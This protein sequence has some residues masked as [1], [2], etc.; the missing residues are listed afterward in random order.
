MS[1]PISSRCAA[2]KYLRRRCPQDCIFSPYFPS[3]DPQRFAYVHRI[4]GASNVGKLLQ[5]LPER[6]RSEATESLYYEA[7]C[8][9]QDPVYGCAGIVSWLQQQIHDVESEIAKTQAEITVFLNSTVNISEPN[10][11]YSRTNEQ[12]MENLTNKHKEPL[13]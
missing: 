13:Q 7:L 11:Q 12:G 1:N 2:C 9:I 5:Q 4:Y 6:A 8:R 3:N 10:T